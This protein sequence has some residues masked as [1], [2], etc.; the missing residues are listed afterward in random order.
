MK[1]RSILCIVFGF[2]LA[3]AACGKKDEGGDQPAAGK[4]GAGQAGKAGAAG[5]AAAKTPAQEA[6][7]M[8]DTLCQ[9]C[10]GASGKG[11]G[12][13][14]AQLD[15]KPRN[16]TDKEWQAKATDE[17]LAKA[18]IGGGTAV[19]LSASMP[20]NPTLEKKPEVVAELIKIIRAFGQ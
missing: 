18:I 19:G 3:F 2:A 14:A 13:G 12:I 15:P 7:G 20:P 10:H 6:R 8:F 4:A 1:Y 5:Q 9:A 16:Y 17:N 11:D